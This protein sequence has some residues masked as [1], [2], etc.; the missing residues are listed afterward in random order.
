MN[1][2]AFQSREEWLEARRLGVGGSDVPAILGLSPWRTAMDVWAEK[3]GVVGGEPSNGYSLRRGQHMEAMLQDE[4]VRE[5]ADA[6]ACV[7]HWTPAE[8]ARSC[9]DPEHREHGL[10][11]AVG[12]EPWMRYSPDG[13]LR[14]LGLGDTTKHWGLVEFKSHPRGASEWSEGVP[15]HVVA[16]V[17]WGLM[18]CGLEVGVACADLGTEVRWDWVH[19]DPAWEA[20]I[21][22]IVR[23]FWKSVETGEPPAPTADDG[24]A[25]ARIYPAHQAGKTVALPGEFLDLRW[26]AD[27]LTKEIKEREKALEEI[28]NRVKAEMKDAET[29]VLV[30]GSG[31]RWKAQEQPATMPDPSKPKIVSRPL[32]AFKKKGSS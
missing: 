22:P 11:I 5:L 25:L 21:L 24:D 9:R 29:G 7:Q 4:V 32:K 17:R 31:W 2:L 10:M 1:L 8:R 18:V 14:F 26:Q 3:R 20:E 27:Q 15:A 28:K 30:D 6:G 23:G 13:F 16:Q 19:R 12:A